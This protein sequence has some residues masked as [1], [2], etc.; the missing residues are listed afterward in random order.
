M[1][2]GSGMGGYGPSPRA[3]ARTA[4]TIA[5]WQGGLAGEASLSASYIPAR[6]GMTD[7]RGGMAVGW[8]GF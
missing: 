3:D 8:D 6:A 7:W 1:P 4:R 5:S 2:A